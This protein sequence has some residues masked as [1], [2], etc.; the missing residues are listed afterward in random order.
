MAELAAASSI[1]GILS[2]TIQVIQISQR[3][4]SGVRNASRT[5][6]GY[7][8][9]LM[10]MRL[11][12]E[13]FQAFVNNEDGTATTCAALEACS[14]ELES[15]RSE[16]HNRMNSNT[17]A[18]RFNRLTWPFAEDETRRRTE[19]LHR[20]QSSLHV[21]LA[22]QNHRLAASTLI[23]I[24][25]LEARQEQH[26]KERI[27]QWL[28]Q[29]DP[30]VNHTAARD[31]HEPST[32]NWF[33]NSEEFIAWKRNDVSNL[34]IRSI[35]G[36]GKT[37]LSST[38]VDHLVHNQRAED[39]MLFYYFDFRNEK[40]QKLRDL[41]RSLIAQIC[42]RADHVPSTIEEAFRRGAVLD[43]R[44]LAE[45]FTSLATEC[46][47]VKIVIDALDESSERSL[48]LDFLKN[49]ADNFTDTVQWL[50]TSRNEQDIGAALAECAPTIVSLGKCLVNDDIRLYIESCLI[51]DPVL[52]SRPEWVKERI[53]ETLLSKAD[54][55]YA[56]LSP[57]YHKC[58][59]CYFT[60][61]SMS[62]NPSYSFY[63]H[64]FEQKSD[65]RQVSICCMS[66][67]CPPRLSHRSYCRSCFGQFTHRY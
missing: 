27:V 49:L 5:I 3:Y 56:G 35:A 36:A 42:V 23:A 18:S 16:L 57:V 48:L 51:R 14:A 13:D 8:R 55:M 64:F 2:L 59:V 10:I 7:F 60:L 21:L 40:K 58:A 31:K 6:R 30:L 41:L 37:I 67:Q 54:G 32:G 4:I 66:A 19:V 50:V 15:L 38:I 61:H 52:R 9:E 20:Y 29:A 11:V 45:M 62:N 1:A 43:T 12:L 46:G 34:W 17:S 22:A 25:R 26:V 33:L 47:Y 39:Y 44:S 24:E 28:S 65:R 53:S 63:T